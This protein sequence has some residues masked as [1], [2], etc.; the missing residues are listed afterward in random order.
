MKHRRSLQVQ[1]LKDYLVPALGNLS[2]VG[3]ELPR[4]GRIANQIKLF[5]KLKLIPSF[6]SLT[7]KDI[8]FEPKKCFDLAI[9]DKMFKNQKNFKDS[10]INY[11]YFAMKT[12]FPIVFLEK[13][14]DV[15][16]SN[17]RL[18]KLKKKLIMT[19][20]SYQFNERFKIWAAEM[21]TKGTKLHIP[22]H[23]GFLPFK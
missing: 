19:T 18:N 8:S 6:Y 10:F 1:Y 7:F 15:Q 14:N 21:I 5:L 22:A 2:S 4:L 11:L 9:R 13:F 12:D 23:G 3:R 17:I 16:K 20:I